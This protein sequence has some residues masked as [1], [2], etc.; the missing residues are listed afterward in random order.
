MPAKTEVVWAPQE[1]PQYALME[2]PLPLIFFGGAR[3]GGKTDGV[4]GKWAAK[5]AIYGDNFNAI[6]FR[7]TTVS[8]E[9]AVERSKQ[10]FGPLGATFNASKLIWR[11]PNGGRVAFAY[12]DKVTDADEYQGRNVTDVWIEEAGQYPAPDP[13]DRL[14][15]VLRSAGGVPVQMILT[16]NPGGPGQGWIRDRFGLYPFPDR[17]LVRTVTINEGTMHAAV[18]PSRITDNRALLNADPHYL[19]RLKMVGS[20]ELVRAWL[21]G[22]WSAI[23]GAFFSDWDESKHVLEPFPIPEQWLRFRSK[24]WGYAAPFS[25]GWWAVASDDTM[26]NGI[27]IPRGAMVR[28]R[29]WYGATGPQKGLRLTAE[30]VADGIKERDQGDLFSYSVMDPAAFSE[31]GGPSIAERMLNRGVTFR[32]ADNAR[33]GREGH[34]G[35]WD[36]MRARMRGEDGVP[37]IFCFSTCRDSIRT[38]PSLQHDPAKAEDLDTEAEDHAADEWRYGCMSRPWVPRGSTKPKPPQRPGTVLLPGAP[39]PMTGVKIRI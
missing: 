32:R 30:Q 6:M 17:P 11:M 14:F 25:V 36:Q 22:D 35:G 13:I 7:R 26:R 38:I 20:K 15:G 5:E 1:G 21:A 8:S 31:D 37:T 12:L 23:E 29:E 27:L 19:E 3:G 18:I 28:Y 9:D 39:K 2:C 33:V 34:L 24:D 10:I 16:G 4:L